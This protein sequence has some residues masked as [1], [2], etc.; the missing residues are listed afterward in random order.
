M[1]SGKLGTAAL[2]LNTWTSVYTVPNGK[3]ATVNIRMVNSDMVN[4][5]SVRL[6][7][8]PVAGAAANAD[9]I[10]P[11]DFV[12]PPSGVVEESALVISPTEIVN[13]YASNTQVAIRVHGFESPILP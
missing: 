2:L 13:A 3:V 9:Y 1:A 8:S 4:P 7:I 11:K 5:V 6:A 12:I 10:L